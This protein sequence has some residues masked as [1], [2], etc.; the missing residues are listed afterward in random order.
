MVS[1]FDPHNMCAKVERITA[2]TGCTSC[3]N[4]M[5]FMYKL[6][7]LFQSTRVSHENSYVTKTFH[8]S[9]LISTQ[10]FFLHPTCNIQSDILKIQPFLTSFAIFHAFNVLFLAK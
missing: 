7:H 4:W 6:D 2:K 1:S 10:D 9:K 3:T 5:H 8:F